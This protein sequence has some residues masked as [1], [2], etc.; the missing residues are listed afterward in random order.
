[1]ATMQPHALAFPRSHV[2]WHR[3]Q[4]AADKRTSSN[5]S[6]YDFG[7]PEESLTSFAAVVYNCTNVFVLI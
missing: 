7:G 2:E 1:M 6:F 3:E 5:F 4:T